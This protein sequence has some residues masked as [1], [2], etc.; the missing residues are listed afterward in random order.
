MNASFAAV[1]A[2]LLATALDAGSDD[3]VVQRLHVRFETYDLVATSC[4]DV[5]AREPEPGFAT[6]QFRYAISGARFSGAHR[7]SG[8]L[9]FSL[10]E[11]VIHVPRAITWPGMTEADRERTARLRRAIEHHEVGHVRIAEAVRDALN[12]EDAITEPDVTAFGAAARARGRDGFDRFKREEREYDALTSHG[13]RQ[14]AAPG[15]LAGPDTALLCP[16]A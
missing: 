3:D 11:I 5:I 1:L 12:A 6:F 16:T 13:R 8:K 14:H 7:Y 10:G 15:D 4:R 9:A 2:A